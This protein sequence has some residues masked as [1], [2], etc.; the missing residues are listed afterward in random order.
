MLSVV[1]ILR[2]LGS[3]D[4]HTQQQQKTQKKSRAFRGRAHRKSMDLLKLQYTI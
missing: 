1:A 2:Y 3:Q 4:Q